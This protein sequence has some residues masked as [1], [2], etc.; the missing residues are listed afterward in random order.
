MNRY[1]RFGLVAGVVSN[2]PLFCPALKLSRYPG[3]GRLLGEQILAV[4][5]A[6]H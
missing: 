4:T 6:L 5:L 2:S 3:P 1:R